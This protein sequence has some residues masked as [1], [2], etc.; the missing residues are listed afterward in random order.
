MTRTLDSGFVAE[1][2][3]GSQHSIEKE[4]SSQFPQE[5]SRWPILRSFNAEGYIFNKNF[6]ILIVRDKLSGIPSM[7]SPTLLDKDPN[8]GD[9]NLE[10]VE[11]WH[12]F[13]RKKFSVKPQDF[14]LIVPIKEGRTIP[15][16]WKN[17]NHEEQQLWRKQI[18]MN[19][20]T[21]Y[22][23]LKGFDNLQD[24]FIPPAY[25]HLTEDCQQFLKDHP[26]YDKN[27]FIMMKFDANN[28]KLKE[29]ED[30]LRQLLKEKGF[31][32]VRADDKVYPKD[33]DLWNNVCV[34][35]ICC[36]Q[37]IAVLE[38]TSKMEFNPNVAIEYGFMRALD[39]R[40]LLLADKNFPKDR[41]DIVGK[42]REDFDINQPKLTIR[43]PI[44]R[45]I[46]EII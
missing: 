1:W 46:D 16:Q 43:D 9:P 37:G 20:S 11:H 25:L 14:I 44:E 17:M 33:R 3:F 6:L 5:S 30:E 32:G 10:N 2:A 38:D 7:G 39:R 31:N 27:V 13:A 4:V 8:L 23:Y 19:L 29:L 34:Y 12:Q 36:K 22:Y 24:F 21:Q 26:T 35:M 28:K 18:S 40:V 45:W 42:L 41:A 15:E